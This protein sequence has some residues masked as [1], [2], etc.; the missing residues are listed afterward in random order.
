M[1]RS[2]PSLNA[3]RAFEAAA[4]HRSF[5]RAAGELH[6]TPAAIS[7]QV[8]ALEAELKIV[9]FHR[10]PRGLVLSE[11]GKAYL[12]G[13]TTALD[14]LAGATR[15]CL[16][17]T[18]A[19]RLTVS[20][21]PSFASGWLIRRLPDFRARYPEI[22]LVIAADTRFV[23]LTRSDIDLAIRYMAGEPIIGE[24]IVGGPIIGGPGGLQ[25]APLMGEEVF[26][27]C[28]PQLLNE[29]PLRRMA[30]LQ[31]HVLLEALTP[32]PN[33]PWIHWR[34]WLDL[35]GIDA[36]KIRPGLSFSDSSHLYQ[37]AMLGQGVALGR[38]ALVG[39]D[40]AAGRLVRPFAELRQARHAYRLV[41]YG[42]DPPPPKTGA[43]IT[44]CREMAGSST[45]LPPV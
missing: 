26:P 21:L 35:A 2:L 16:A 5:Q 40:L 36:S 17:G 18:P 8:K 12:P 33:E 31:H 38:S 4:R 37:A 1:V 23:D 41:W 19:G 29:V 32:A 42:D 34:P 43:F 7:Q 3:I 39:D 45:V 44:W 25:S 11:A 6:V 28:A 22:E 24:P 13:V 30:D 9:L 10:Q 14:Q 15:H 27:V 20:V